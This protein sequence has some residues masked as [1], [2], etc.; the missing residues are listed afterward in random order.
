M[1]FSETRREPRD[2]VVM[3][4]V[5]GTLGVFYLL[6]EFGEAGNGYR[7]VGVGISDVTIFDQWLSICRFQ[8]FGDG[9]RLLGL[10]EEMRGRR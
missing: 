6:Q 7:P 4:Q 2:N 5:L 8:V 3:A 9:G 10:V 1:T